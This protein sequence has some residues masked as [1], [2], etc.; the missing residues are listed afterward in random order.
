LQ[1]TFF[2]FA[3]LAECF[4]NE[5]REN[6]MEKLWVDKIKCVNRLKVMAVGKLSKF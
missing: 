3:H 2:L 1:F 6:F 4:L 5:K